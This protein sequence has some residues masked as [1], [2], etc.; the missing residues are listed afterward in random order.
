MIMS[1]PSSSSPPDATT[2]AFDAASRAAVYR[3]IEQRRDMRHFAGGCVEPTVLVRLLR[4]AH[5][6][7]SVGF[8]Q[9]WRWIR[10]TQGEMRRR[11]HELVQ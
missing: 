1:D 10:I 5:W 6:A 3:A 7:P 11:L 8:M 4:A 9:P 2:H